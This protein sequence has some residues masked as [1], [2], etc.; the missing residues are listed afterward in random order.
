MQLVLESLLHGDLQVPQMNTL[1][2]PK[3]PSMLE[4]V[5][6]LGTIVSIL[7]PKRGTKLRSC[8]IRLDVGPGV[9]EDHGQ[10]RGRTR[11]V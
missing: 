6:A 4:G 5:N 10:W 3:P 9:A 7:Q 11:A 1:H 2:I 8:K